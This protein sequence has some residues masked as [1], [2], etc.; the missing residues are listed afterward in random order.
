MANKWA[1]ANGNWSDGSTWNDGVVPAV[2]DDVW[3][4]GYEVYVSSDIKINN[5]SNV[6]D[7]TFTVG[8]KLVFGNND[9]KIECNII[10]S[11]NNIITFNNGYNLY[12]DCRKLYSMTEYAFSSS[13]KDKQTIYGTNPNAAYSKTFCYFSGDIET[14]ENSIGSVFL[15]AYASSN[16]YFTLN[17]T[18]NIIHKGG[19]IAPTIQLY[20]SYN[21]Y[22]IGNLTVYTN[23][24]LSNSSNK[25]FVYGNIEIYNI[26]SFDL[27]NQQNYGDIIVS[28][29]SSLNLNNSKNYGTIY[30]YTK[31]E[32]IG[33]ALSWSNECVVTNLFDYTTCLQFTTLNNANYKIN[34]TILGNVH[35]GYHE[36]Y[37]S[38]NDG[39]NRLTSS[40]NGKLYVKTNQILFLEFIIDNPDIFEYIYEGEGE[41]TFEIIPYK[42]NHRLNYPTEQ[43]VAQGV[44]YG[45]QNEYEGRLALP[46]ESTVLKDVEY[47]DDKVGTLEVIAL[48]GATATADN[49]SVVNLTEHQLQRVSNC[50]TVSTVQKCFED[51]KEE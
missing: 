38:Y 5:L 27:G 26:N 33:K 20:S 18:G 21:G 4:N 44:T 2:D 48:S 42:G 10:N 7:S 31:N 51:F 39:F 16:N 29:N 46:P 40:E 19:Y 30:L 23:P 8:G 24:F 11:I 36:S 22:I 1:I 45:M 13:N 9:Y 43:Q 6:S 25:A 41:P 28:P 49:I 47:G 12:I 14:N 35:I 15:S 32:F 50:A 17:I 3:L 34:L 37:S